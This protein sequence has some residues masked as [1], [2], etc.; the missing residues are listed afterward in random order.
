MSREKFLP[1]VA[2]V[3]FVDGTFE[4][5]PLNNGRAVPPS[6]E[7]LS[8]EESDFLVA[9][10]RRELEELRVL[11]DALRKPAEEIR[12]EELAK[13]VALVNSVQNLLASYTTN[14]GQ[15]CND[16]RAAWNLNARYL[17]KNF[18]AQNEYLAKAQQ[19]GAGEKNG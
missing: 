1:R 6:E 17:S 11:Y 9:E 10:A 3:G 4:A 2:V 5:D 19:S 16:I 14:S 18:E 12:R 15:S 13:S 7:Y 8:R